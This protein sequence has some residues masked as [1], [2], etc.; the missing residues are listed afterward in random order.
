M[1]MGIGI[2]Y[3]P[4]TDKVF[5]FGAY[6]THDVWLRSADNRVALGLRPATIE[7]IESLP[8]NA[9]SVDEIR[10]AA[11]RDGIVRIRDFGNRISVQFQARRGLRDL[12]FKIKEVLNRFFQPSS[13]VTIHNLATGEQTE[14]TLIDLAQRLSNDAPILFRESAEGEVLDVPFDPALNMFIDNKIKQ[15]EL[16]QES[17]STIEDISD[18][19]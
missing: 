7:Y 3:N 18:K 4:R 12:L 14:L 11:I 6:D 5:N 1:P 16:D 9:Q 2:W 17:R 13:M 8:T 10:L 15:I 19:L